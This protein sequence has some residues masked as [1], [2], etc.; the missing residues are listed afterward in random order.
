LN[1]LWDFDVL[2]DWT[3]GLMLRVDSLEISLKLST[4]VKQNDQIS[5]KKKINPTISLCFR[6]TFNA[7]FDVATSLQRFHDLLLFDLA[8]PRCFQVSFVFS[9]L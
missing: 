3:E 8:L 9:F 6:K 4:V 1:V 7:S 2:M 5:L